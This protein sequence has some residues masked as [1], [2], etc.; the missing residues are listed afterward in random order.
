MV[1]SGSFRRVLAS[2]GALLL[3]L[4]LS[5][6]AVLAQDTECSASVNPRAAV[7]GSV[8]V[9]SGSGYS[10]T[11]LSLQK[12]DDEPINHDLNVGEADPWEVTV[13]SRVGD[14]GTWTASFEDPAVPCTATTEFRVTL[15]NTDAISD[16][17]TA[18]RSGSTPIALYLGVIVVGFG[19]GLFIGR[20]MRDRRLA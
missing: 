3:M 11:K 14:E 20:L 7:G 5:A 17:V 18:A 13:R 4:T 1:S 16:A 2:I 8:F 12:E 15:S 19:G 6:G 9:F 10:P